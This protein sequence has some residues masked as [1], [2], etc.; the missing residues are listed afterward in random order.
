MMSTPGPSE[1]PNESLNE[2]TPSWGAWGWQGQA[3]GKL[4]PG[5]TV[6]SGNLSC[7][8]A[9]HCK[10][11]LGYQWPT[12]ARNAQRTSAREALCGMQPRAEDSQWTVPGFLW[13]CFIMSGP[14]TSQACLELGRKSGSGGDWRPEDYLATNWGLGFTWKIHTM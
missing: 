10:R 9:G 6:M 12:G 13:T 8:S 3:A 2:G 1:E 14:R 7:P 11:A 5:E 4:W